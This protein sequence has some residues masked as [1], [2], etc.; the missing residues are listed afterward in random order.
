MNRLVAC[1]T[2]LG[3]L[4]YVASAQ[5]LTVTTTADASVLA[6]AVKSAAGSAVT[7]TSATYEGAPT[8]SGT[9]TDGPLGISNGA[10]FT[11][12]AAELALPPSD[13]AGTTQDNGLPGSPLCDA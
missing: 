6:N 4:A 10:L 3:C 12:G 11:S 1:C 7:V 13:G 2:G 9:Y 8:A 5:A